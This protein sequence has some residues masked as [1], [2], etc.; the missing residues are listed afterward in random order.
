MP[1]RNSRN[2]LLASQA[3]P[4]SSSQ[5][6][7]SSSTGASS[8]SP[9]TAR[10]TQLSN[11]RSRFSRSASYDSQADG[12]P[13]M[14][15]LGTRVECRLP[16]WVRYY[17][18]RVAAV[19]NDGTL[20]VTFEDG[21][22]R[23]CVQL[24]NVVFESR[25][26]P[27]S[28]P[29]RIRLVLGSQVEVSQDQQRFFPARVTD[30][31]ANDKF[32]LTLCDGRSIQA[33][34]DQIKCF[35]PS[36]GSLVADEEVDILMHETRTWVS[37]RIDETLTRVVFADDRN[38]T[39]Q[40]LAVSD[41]DLRY[42]IVNPPRQ[43]EDEDSLD[44]TPM[45]LSMQER[46]S[47]SIEVGA[48]ILITDKNGGALPKTG[49]ADSAQ[50]SIINFPL[51]AD[52]VIESITLR[53]FEPPAEESTQLD[54]ILFEREQIATG[55]TRTHRLSSA[56]SSGDEGGNSPQM[57]PTGST[58]STD[59]Q[60]VR[61][62]VAP[63]LPYRPSRSQVMVDPHSRSV[64]H[65]KLLVPLRGSAGQYLGIM[66][67]RGRLN[68]A[69]TPDKKK[70]GESWSE[71]SVEVFYMMPR[72]VPKPFAG[73][74]HATR[75]WHGRA[76]WFATM[77]VSDPVDAVD[78]GWQRRCAVDA[79]AR[80]DGTAEI[81]RVCWLVTS[82][83]K[84]GRV[85]ATFVLFECPSL[86]LAMRRLSEID[87]SVIEL[88]T[89]VCLAAIGKSTTTRVSSQK[90]QPL[91]RLQR[92]LHFKAYEMQV[93]QRGRLATN[94]A[95]LQSI[96]KCLL[97]IRRLLRLVSAPV[98]SS[99]SSFV[100]KVT[101]KTL[102]PRHGDGIPQ[103]TYYCKRDGTLIV[104]RSDTPQ[105][106]RPGIDELSL[107][108]QSSLVV[109]ASDDPDES[110]FI[111]HLLMCGPIADAEVF[112]NDYSSAS[113]RRWQLWTSP[114]ELVFKTNLEALGRI[115]QQ[116]DGRSGSEDVFQ[117]KSVFGES[118]LAQR[119]WLDDLERAT[120]LLSSF[121]RQQ[122]PPASFVREQL[123]LWKQRKLR[124]FI[125][126]S[127]PSSLSRSN[128]E[129]D[130]DWGNKQWTVTIPGASRLK[131]EWAAQSRLQEGSGAAIS[132]SFGNSQTAFGRNGLPPP[133]DRV[134]GD[135]VTIRVDPCKAYDPG[136]IMRQSRELISKT[137]PHAQGVV[138]A[139]GDP[140]RVHVDHKGEARYACKRCL[141]S[142]AEG[143]SGLGQCCEA[144]RLPENVEGRFVSA[145]PARGS[146]ACSVCVS[147]Q[148]PCMACASFASS[149]AVRSARARTKASFRTV[150]QYES[151][152]RRVLV[153]GVPVHVSKGDQKEL[154]RFTKMT[155]EGALVVDP[156]GWASS[157]DDGNAAT[158]A[159]MILCPIEHLALV[160]MV[161]V[162][163]SSSSSSQ[164]QHP[165]SGSTTP[166]PP[167]TLTPPPSVPSP[168]SPSRARSSMMHR[169]GPNSSPSPSSLM[170]MA[171]PAEHVLRH[172]AFSNAIGSVPEISDW[173]G[174]HSHHHR[175]GASSG[176]TFAMSDLGPD[177]ALSNNGLTV[178]RLR[179]LGWGTQRM[180]RYLD[181][182]CG[183]TTITFRIDRNT[184][185][186]L[187]FGVV[188]PSFDDWSRRMMEPGAW[189][190]RRDGSTHADGR[191]RTSATPDARLV[192]GEALTMIV[193][194][195]SEP[196]SVTFLRG[197]VVL[198]KLQGLPPR[199][200][201]AVSF[202]GSNQVVTI[203]SF[204]MG[205]TNPA[206][207]ASTAA[208]ASASASSSSATTSHRDTDVAGLGAIPPEWGFA[209]SVVPEYDELDPEE[210]AAYL[211]NV[212][213]WTVKQD[214]LLVMYMDEVASEKKYTLLDVL[215]VPLEEFLK[216]GGGRSSP[217]LDSLLQED[218]TIESISQRL[219][220]I[221]TFNASLVK[222][223]PLLD[224]AF[225]DEGGTV[226]TSIVRDLS[227]CSHLIL[228]VV[229]KPM[230]EDAL[231]CTRTEEGQFE[232]MLDYGR[233]LAHRQFVDLHGRFTIFGQAFRAMN[234]M[235][236]SRLRMRGQLYRATLRGM[237]AHDDGG[238]YRQSF[239]TYCAELLST[240]GV[241]L[242]LPCANRSNEIHV[243]RDR[244]LPNPSARSALQ[245]SMFEFVGKLMGIAL[246]NNEFLD[247]RLPSLVW[248][249]LVN[250]R[251]TFE[252]LRAVD[253]LFANTVQEMLE[254][255]KDDQD[256]WGEE[257]GG[258]VTM[259]FT[260][261][262]LDGRVCELVPG[263]EQ[264]LVA[265]AQDRQ[266][267]VQLA[268]QF[269]LNEFNEQLEAIR[270][271]LATV[272]PQRMLVLFTWEEL[273]LMVCG[274]PRIDL[275]LLKEM[276]VYVGC[277]DSDPHI[278]AFWRVLNSFS[279]ETRSLYLRFVWGRSRLPA[280]KHTWG[281]TPHKISSFEASLRSGVVDVDSL[282]PRSHTCYFSLDLPKYS[283]EDVLRRK[284][285]FAIENCTEIDADQT[286]TGNR[287]AA[288]GFDLDVDLT[289]VDDQV[290]SPALSTA[291]LSGT[292]AGGAMGRNGP[293][294]SSETGAIAGAAAPGSTSPYHS[295]D[296]SQRRASQSS[297]GSDLD[298]VDEDEDVF[299][300]E[301]E[302]LS[303][304]GHDFEAM[305][306]FASDAIIDFG[307]D[308]D[309]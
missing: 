249:W 47:Q 34:R 28:G 277:T 103:V 95:S 256:V 32:T 202:G 38:G 16:A 59:L 174:T 303:R 40:E 62:Y 224:L 205:G 278:Q 296:N 142:I 107:S 264:R 157:G 298:V 294:S 271:G 193:D 235:P 22:L 285:L 115:Q 284:L 178:T 15:L 210:E 77:V 13:R 308:D 4:S 176:G 64:Q 167:S 309:E 69:Y 89:N 154:K 262:S 91:V 117:K 302:I 225:D 121:A 283:S 109:P 222:A 246:R 54:V 253:L 149:M 267:W 53:L 72:M 65:V 196:R 307:S 258:G 94:V 289:D 218:K 6:P 118:E 146:W 58:S 254:A 96:L 127:H 250:R 24:A 276:T 56:E 102:S 251:P 140:V 299:E 295:R 18:G 217:S 282:L 291:T 76:G 230:W 166:P 263:G 189:S 257:F 274:R 33:S 182:S 304:L 203:T 148:N 116:G 93:V 290:G 57:G 244:W 108:S 10:P 73:G 9:A 78:P 197:S 122:T 55:P 169:G 100:A 243:N 12:P 237:R 120:T 17:P 134:E 30:I 141:L 80:R 192:T 156:A 23:D 66:N 139:G 85:D 101:R 287:S 248:K 67:R 70:P 1:A 260:I 20:M 238:P 215:N 110:E 125:E 240:P 242:F 37:G 150:A 229:K 81:R 232:V 36:H 112:F 8:A 111:K 137:F 14:Y 220:W 133:V 75:D 153:P 165:Q 171:P 25:I 99:P 63:D 155:P 270:R 158:E 259:N 273:E 5:L 143:A 247:L 252:D 42:P 275:Q 234:P 68:I 199:V 164:Q 152:L 288:L 35:I 124:A 208:S 177:I 74:P 297:F 26:T 190:I 84:D 187:F 97:T 44:A 3:Q 79:L 159:E 7:R 214:R 160:P 279:E 180:A 198:G 301:G 191:E 51:P 135:T 129:G 286:T 227:E 266:E 280:S 172:Y 200:V 255:P 269:K 52:G 212:A 87:D 48:H 31:L 98:R 186:H 292:V 305:N 82:L 306:V 131:L 11:V 46:L 71:K 145:F 60:V 136:E 201:P 2:V 161:T 281:E 179:S 90:L 170:M 181:V 209:L 216:P 206:I 185:N 88:V 163:S 204:V 105:Q 27:S 221:R 231:E 147:L 228:D 106:L 168:V 39:E 114:V 265:F 123:V 86:V 300:A 132:I 184:S 233:A 293:S 83:V 194:M 195:I 268:T 245:I 261:Y 104:S 128:G 130:H 219:E 138:N 151:F 162:A 207:A 29:S 223:L 126:S 113:A 239:Q 43:T 173:L 211:V 241:G 213:N 119:D 19:N 183:I 45:I 21:D 50:V 236:P 226:D 272:V 41:V 49:K 188:A 92:A 144:M 61:F 175:G